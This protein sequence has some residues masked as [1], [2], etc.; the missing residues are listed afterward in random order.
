[1]YFLSVLRSYHQ[2]LKF[3]SFRLK[4]TY[5]FLTHLGVINV[6]C[7]ATTNIS[8]ADR[9]YASNVV[10]L[11]IAHLVNVKDL[12]NVQTVQVITLPTLSNV[13]HGR[14][15]RKYLRLYVN[16]TSRSQRHANNTNSFRQCKYMQVQL[17][18]ILAINQHNR[19]K[20]KH[21]QIIA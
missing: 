19:N 17:S 1:M 9:L 13:Q 20:N 14:K 11:N 16:R 18:L 5:T 6:K 21:K 3:V 15:R 2:Q 4:L 10:C 8:G 7:L 12:L